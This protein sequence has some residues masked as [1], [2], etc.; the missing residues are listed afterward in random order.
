[1]P[2]SARSAPSTLRSVTVPCRA[3]SSAVAKPPVSS[4]VRAPK[5]ASIVGAASAPARYPA[6]LAVFIA[7]AV[8]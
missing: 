1:M 5:R 4:T 8:R 3:S 2:V 6:A 7:P